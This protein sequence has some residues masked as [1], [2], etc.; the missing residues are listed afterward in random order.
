MVSNT[1]HNRLRNLVVRFAPGNLCP[2]VVNEFPR[3]GGGWV[4]RLLAD[5]MKIPFFNRRPSLGQGIVHGHY[6]NIPE[7]RKV[8]A[9]FRDGRDVMVSWYHHCFFEN[10]INNRR[11]VKTMRKALPLDDYQDVE[12]NMARFIEFSFTRTIYPPF[13]WHQFAQR[14]HMNTP[15]RAIVRYEDLRQQ[16]AEVLQRLVAEL[17]GD[18]ISLD[19]ATSVAERHTFRRESGREPGTEAANSYFRKG[20]IG[21][22]RNHFNADARRTFERYAGASLIALGYE[23]DAG[24]VDSE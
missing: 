13:N 14:W 3:S 17:S 4:A 9:V 8:V 6:L 22:W 10:D 12:G 16:T 20:V 15:G 21:D 19:V 1:F 11:L 18:P 5:A 24:W 2:I 7:S 23:R